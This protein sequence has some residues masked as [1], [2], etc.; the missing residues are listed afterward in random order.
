MCA[1]GELPLPRDCSEAVRRADRLALLQ[2]LVQ[3]PSPTF[4]HQIEYRLLKKHH[5]RSGTIF[6]RL[7]LKIRGQF[8][9]TKFSGRVGNMLSELLWNELAV[10]G[11]AATSALKSDVLGRMWV[12]LKRGSIY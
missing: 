10:I 11:M 12:I 1:D 3:W 2:S 4:E 5:Q 8:E 9:L 7:L 6:H